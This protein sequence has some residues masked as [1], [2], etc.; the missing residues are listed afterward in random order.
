ME[1]KTAL[2]YALKSGQFK[3]S[4]A[5]DIVGISPQQFG[6]YTSGINVPSFNKG[7]D[8]L[9]KLDMKVVLTKEFKDEQTD[10]SD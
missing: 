1:F 9:K 7:V 8:M 10:V 5:A 4:E 2:N 6:C 3:K